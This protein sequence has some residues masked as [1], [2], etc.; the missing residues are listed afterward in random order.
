MKSQK[1][2]TAILISFIILLTVI[3]HGLGM[4][5]S[6]ERFFRNIVAPTSQN[7]YEWS[8]V[9]GEERETFENP[10]ELQHAYTTLKQ[11][12]LQNQIDQVELERLTQENSDLRA[13]LAF[14]SSQA[15]SSLATDVI[16]KNIDPLGSSIVVGAGSDAGVQVGDPVVVEEGIL[17]GRV[18]HIEEDIAVVR[19]MDDRQSKVAAMLFNQERSIGVV[20]GGFGL[21][22]RMNFIPQNEIVD[23]GDKIVSSGLE[24]GLPRGLLIGDVVAVEQEPYQPFQSALV[25]PAFD[26]NFLTVVS[27]LRT[28]KGEE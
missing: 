12:Y 7:L 20:E 21:S 4:L 14:V 13:Q 22:I 19:L 3:A 9:I 15:F 27:I 8:V 6:V 11:T 25:S 1:A 2:K 17:I 5:N 18:S 16:G 26:L 28:Q 23:V 24:E 10:K